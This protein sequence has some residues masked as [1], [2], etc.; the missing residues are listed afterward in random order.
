MKTNAKCLCL[1][2]ISDKKSPDV[3]ME[4]KFVQTKMEEHVT[5]TRWDI[6]VALK[7]FEEIGVK[8][9]RRFRREFI[10]QTTEW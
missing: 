8:I 4:E 9:D 2:L 3:I 1:V 5:N 10:K 7:R 6:R